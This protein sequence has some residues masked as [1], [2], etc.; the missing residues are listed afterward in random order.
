MFGMSLEG[1]GFRIEDIVWRE[2]TP[3]REPS[4]QDLFETT[5]ERMASVSKGLGHLTTRRTNARK[6]EDG[7]I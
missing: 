7:E 5:H 1:K 2:R 4:L 3:V 6:K